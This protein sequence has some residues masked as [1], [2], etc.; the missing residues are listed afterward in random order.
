MKKLITLIIV[1][2]LAV[3]AIAVETTP[4]WGKVLTT[5]I[6]TTLPAQ[7][8]EARA[9]DSTQL[10]TITTNL[11]VVD[12]IV[13]TILASNS[14]VFTKTGIAQTVGA[15]DSIAVFTVTTG[16]VEIEYLYLEV[17][18]EYAGA[19]DSVR[20]IVDYPGGYTARLDCGE[21]LNAA[22]VGT[23]FAVAAVA[24]GTATTKTLIGV[25]VATPTLKMIL[26]SG[27]AITLLDAG[28]GTTGRAKVIC[29][30][31]PIEAGARLN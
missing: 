26:Q 17:T 1:L 16:A 14:I 27:T 23:R 24:A 31:R 21:E 6:G 13:D 29:K 30:Y 3:N 19:T 5:G 2:L 10:A 18:T 9:D 11:A 28:T 25:P 4:N 7:I 12:A 22:A 8:Q 20:F 15:N